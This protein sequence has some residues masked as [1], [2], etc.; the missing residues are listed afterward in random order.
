MSAQSRKNG[1]QREVAANAGHWPIVQ[2]ATMDIMDL[3]N[4]RGVVTVAMGPTEFGAAPAAPTSATVAEADPDA[5]DPDAGTA[6]VI[7]G[8]LHRD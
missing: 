6:P 3:G 5:A 7:S 8:V 1:K 2:R 4:R